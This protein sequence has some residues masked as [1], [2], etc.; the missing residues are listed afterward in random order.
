[1][2]EVR[3]EVLGRSELDRSSEGVLEFEL[4]LGQVQQAGGGSGVELDQEIDVTVRTEVVA[5]GRAEQCE[6]SD[7]VAASEHDE[8]G[9]VEGQTRSQLHVVIMPHQG[10]VVALVATDC[11]MSRRGAGVDPQSFFCGGA[12]SPQAIAETQRQPSRGKSSTWG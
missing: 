11:R 3:A 9:L 10:A 2:P 4:H 6:A 12:V 1:M 8:E 7:A 5:Q